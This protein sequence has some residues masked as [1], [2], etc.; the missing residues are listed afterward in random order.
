MFK[1]RKFK[2]AQKIT[3]SISNN[4]MQNSKSTNEWKLHS[5]DEDDG[6]SLIFTYFHT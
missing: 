3:D 5:D 2:G 6:K 4:V 1:K